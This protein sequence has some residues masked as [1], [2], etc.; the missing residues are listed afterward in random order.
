MEKMGDNE[1]GQAY[2]FPLYV[3]RQA[4]LLPRVTASG[5]DSFGEFHPP[6][7]LF[8]DPVSEAH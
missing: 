6:E 5:K 7:I 1:H 4:L 8:R 3:A 2:P